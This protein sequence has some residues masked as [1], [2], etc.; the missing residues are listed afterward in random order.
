MIP[1]VQ[2]ILALAGTLLGP[3]VLQRIGL[4]APPANDNSTTGRVYVMPDHP[5]APPAPGAP[6]GTTPSTGTGSTTPSTGSGSTTPSTGSTAPSAPPVKQ[7]VA[8]AV[9]QPWA[10]FGIGLILAVAPL[11]ISQLRATGHDLADGTRGV[12]AEGQ[13]KYRRIDNAD[14]Y[15]GLERHRKGRR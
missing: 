8:D 11:T 9:R 7:I 5:S 14:D 1:L 13:R 4:L 6:A 3:Q 10:L 15:T 12:Y 2:V